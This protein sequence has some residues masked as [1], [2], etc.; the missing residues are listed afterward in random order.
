MNICFKNRVTP[1][2]LYGMVL[3]FWIFFGSGCSIGTEVGNGN[4]PK[5]SPTPQT[6]TPTSVPDSA[7][8][9]EGEPSKSKSE[10]AD[11]NESP[12]SEST[13][14]ESTSSKSDSPTNGSPTSSS[15]ST[16]GLSPVDL[17]HHLLLNT[18]A[19]P[20][21][22]SNLQ[23]PASL[24]AAPVVQ[25]GSLLKIAV[26][27]SDVNDQTIFEWGQPAKARY[28]IKS[29]SVSDPLKAGITD[30]SSGQTTSIGAAVKCGNP[31]IQNGS[32]LG[33]EKGPLQ[34]TTVDLTFQGQTY[35]LSWYLKDTPPT[36]TMVLLR[37][38]FPGQG[39]TVDFKP[40]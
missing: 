19:S 24:V 3:T 34:G 26:Y 8:S 27:R 23:K 18:C 28:G 14:P 5:P 2:C 21:S 17:I 39:L 11:S 7:S 25:G 6:Q 22:L 16:E 15:T 29:A 9:P 33:A 36:K 13:S 20:W 35:S 37:I 38:V 12:S 31:L 32:L 1:D 30:L 4:K 40:N 10:K